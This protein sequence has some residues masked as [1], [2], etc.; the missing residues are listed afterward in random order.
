[1][2]LLRK[3]VV[4]ENACSLCYD[5]VANTKLQPCGH[6]G[7]CEKCVPLLESCPF[8]RGRIDRFDIINSS[9]GGNDSNDNASQASFASA[10][11]DQM[12]SPKHNEKAEQ[13]D[14]DE[15]E[16]IMTSAVNND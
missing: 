4:V 3:E 2:K 1:M 14:E 16:R 8:C 6:E 10:V 13:S 15:L 7:F 5:E 11:S 9:V 12:K